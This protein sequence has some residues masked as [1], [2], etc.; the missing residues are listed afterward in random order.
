MLALAALLAGIL[1]VVYCEHI[2]RRLRSLLAPNP[3][4]APEPKKADGAAPEKVPAG[5]KTDEASEWAAND[6]PGG[7]RRG[8]VAAADT[9]TVTQLVIGCVAALVVGVTGGS[10]LI[11]LYYDEARY[12]LASK[13]AVSYMPSLGIGTLLGGVLCTA[14][15]FAAVLARGGDLPSTSEVCV[16]VLPGL[17]MGLIFTIDVVCQLIALDTFDLPYATVFPLVR[18]NVVV[19]GLW[20]ICVFGELRDGA[21]ITVFFASCGAVLVGAVLLALYGP[22]DSR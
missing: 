11:P 4:A 8:G 17:A 16:A 15:S 12:D 21:S 13:V 18:C 6:G 3:Y 20:G 2:G 5:S 7:L 22:Q 10:F 14:A 19:A 1:G 9:R